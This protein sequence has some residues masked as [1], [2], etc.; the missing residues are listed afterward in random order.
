MS[1]LVGL[2]APA[3]Y[4]PQ[5]HDSHVELAGPES[6]F[7]EYFKQSLKYTSSYCTDPECCS[8]F[9]EHLGSGSEASYS[10][11]ASNTT[12]K[13]PL[14]LF[15]DLQDLPTPTVLH[16]LAQCFHTRVIPSAPFL[17]GVPSFSAHRKSKHFDLLL[18]KALLG[19][20][21]SK[22]IR[23]RQ[24]T[25][26]LWQACVRL[27]TASVAVDNSLGRVVGWL[28]AVRYL[29][30]CLNTPFEPFCALTPDFFIC[31]HC[32]SWK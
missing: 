21:T 23:H 5:R 26:K 22:D 1:W 18:C 7:F 30:L 4:V 11:D 15:A 3:E 27:A 25:D 29:H 13:Y 9:H 16:Q 32:W 31:T 17:S 10:Q 2:Y 28:S 12:L 14:A 6:S 20:F 19:A 24:L 8:F